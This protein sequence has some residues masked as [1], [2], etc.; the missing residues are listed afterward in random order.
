V[1][2]NQLSALLLTREREN[3]KAIGKDEGA[4]FWIRRRRRRLGPE[5]RGHGVESA[6]CR[7]HCHRASAELRRKRLDRRIAAWGGGVDDRY[8]AAFSI[9]TE[10]ELTRIVEDNGVGTLADRGVP[11]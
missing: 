3:H 10:N 1:L 9:G 8:R 4:S 2:S 6:C 11:R 7:I 5:R